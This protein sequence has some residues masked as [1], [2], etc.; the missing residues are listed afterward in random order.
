MAQPGSN[1]DHMLNI[2]VEISD[3]LLSFRYR[4]NLFLVFELFQFDESYYFPESIF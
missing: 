3:N 1:P 4:E 2:A